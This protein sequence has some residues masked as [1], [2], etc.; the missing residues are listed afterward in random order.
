[1]G[2]KAGIVEGLERISKDWAKNFSKSWTQKELVESAN[3]F[4]QTKDPIPRNDLF[5]RFLN[6]T[7]ILFVHI[8]T[9]GTYRTESQKNGFP[10]L[11]YIRMGNEDNIRIELRT[12]NIVVLKKELERMGCRCT[13]QHPVWKVVRK[14]P[15]SNVKE[16][17]IQ[18]DTLLVTL[19]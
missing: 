5:Y 2:E 11:P 12:G 19:G 9:L 8:E 3:K 1:M 15:L 4:N 18:N 14:F 17:K 10:F 13:I 16:I 7:R 6:A